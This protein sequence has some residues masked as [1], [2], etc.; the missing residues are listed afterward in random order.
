MHRKIPSGLAITHKIFILIC[1]WISHDTGE[2]VDHKRR[3]I[4]EKQSYRWIESLKTTRS[5][6]SEKI[7]TRKKVL[8]CA[9]LHRNPRP[10]GRRGSQIVS[11]I[12]LHKNLNQI[13]AMT[14]TS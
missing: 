4:T 7:G 5:S 1:F 3:P 2:K 11:I 13:S 14:K 6:L 8:S 12:R 9:T 10:L